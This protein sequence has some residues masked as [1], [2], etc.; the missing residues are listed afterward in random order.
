[1]LETAGTVLLYAVAGGF[2]SLLL[3]LVVCPILSASWNI[4]ADFLDGFFAVVRAVFGAV[5]S[6]PFRVIDALERRRNPLARMTPEQRHQWANR[7]GP[8]A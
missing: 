8:Y 7:E 3:V 5:I 6:A 1:V 4:I 2:G